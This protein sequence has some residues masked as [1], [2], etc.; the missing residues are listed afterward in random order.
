MMR[1]S[2]PRRQGAP[3]SGAG[4]VDRP[5]A[6]V[7]PAVRT[8]EGAGFVV[9]RPFPTGHLELFDPFLLLD[10]MGPVDY[11]PGEAVG[12]PD[13]PHRGFETVTYVLEGE[14]EHRDSHGGHGRI[15]PGGVQWMTAGAGIVHAEMPAEHI[16]R[17]GGRVHGFQ[18]WVNLPSRHKMLPPRYQGIGAADLPSVSGQGWALKVVAGEIAGTRGPASTHT[19]V[20]VAHLTARPGALLS[21]DV[22][23][24]HNA[25][26][27]VFGGRV[28]ITDPD[29]RH[30]VGAHELAV[31]H[32]APGALTLGVPGDADDDLEALVLAGSPLGEPVARYGPFVM[33][34]RRELVDAVED[35][36]AG[37]MGAIAPST[38]GDPRRCDPEGVHRNGPTKRSG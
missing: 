8:L 10:E 36:R 7:V 21:L 11:A 4:A 17:H 30:E 1:N 28:R 34:T 23:D 32:R 27:Y 38:D 24:E 18:I 12:A 33:T 14:F 16:R 35:H 19:P 3:A 9:H 26:V 31:W 37:R 5:L 2:R 22:P 29:G 25:G 13:H 20:V 6:R 15:G